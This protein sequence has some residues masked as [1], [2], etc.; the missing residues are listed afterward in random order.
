MDGGRCHCFD[1]PNWAHVFSLLTIVLGIMRDGAFYAP[2]G[3][4]P[5]TKSCA[6]HRASVSSC[7]RR[8]GGKQ[9]SVL[10]P[11][12]SL[13]LRNYKASTDKHKPTQ[14]VA[15]VSDGRV[16]AAPS[17]GGGLTGPEAR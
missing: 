15:L 10:L 11:R 9:T 5:P 6:R 12:G 2:R 14:S 8:R 16:G 1:Q 17:G 4:A 13:F 7:P 3:K